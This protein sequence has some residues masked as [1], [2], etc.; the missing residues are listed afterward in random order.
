M[1]FELAQAQAN[2]INQAQAALGGGSA[3]AIAP[4]RT[5]AT[6]VSGLDTLNA[7]LN[8][9]R[10][11]TSKLCESIGGPFPVGGIAKDSPPASGAVGRINDSVA[12]AHTTL[13][14]IESLLN[15]IARSLG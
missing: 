7:R 2:Y 12:S 13:G 4:P 9:V 5:I 8:E 11:L 3:N 6:A 1:N 14:E 10:A 15:T